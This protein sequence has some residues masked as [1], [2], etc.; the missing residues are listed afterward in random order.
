MSLAFWAALGFWLGAAALFYTFGGYALIMNRLARISCGSAVSREIATLCDVCVVLVARNEES[1]ITARIE[2]L[3]SSDYP[4]SKLRIIVVSDGS[5]DATFDRAVNLPRVETVAQPERAGKAAG[6]NAGIARS[7]D[8]LIVFTDARQT[9]APETISR[10]AAHFTDPQV[11]AVSGELV[12]QDAASGLGEGVGAYWRMEKHLRAAEARVDSCIGCTGAVYAIRRALYEPIAADT[13]LD[14]VVIPMTIATRGYRVLHDPRA[15]AFDP[16]PLEPAA[17]RRRKRRTLA[18]NFQMLFRHPRWLLPRYNRLWWQL[19]SHKYLRLLAPA[20]LA[21]LLAANVLLFTT[22]F[23]RI[24]LF[25]QIAF[26]TLAAVGSAFPG[27]RWR[28]V[29]LPASFIFLNLSVVRALADF[30]HA[31]DLHLWAASTERQ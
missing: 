17:E 25:G 28:I 27:I 21:Q 16:Q 30:L 24:T 12:I 19:I 3:L 22:P 18:G 31:R 23:Y 7:A 20:L 8:A 6:L 5:T 1:R 29:A 10:L 15:L 2:N 26:Y 11:G 13:I 14:D 9:F 4:S